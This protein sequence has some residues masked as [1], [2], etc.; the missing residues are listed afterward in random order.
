MLV[1]GM[2]R[3]FPLVTFPYSYPMVGVLEVDFR[4]DDR[5]V[6]P[7]EKLVDKRERVAVLNR[8]GI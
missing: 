1:T 4:E 5:A 7:I 6:K 8:E 2:E 3:Y